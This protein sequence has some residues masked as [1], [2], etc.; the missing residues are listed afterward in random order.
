[1][2]S[3]PSP[4]VLEGPPPWLTEDIEFVYLRNLKHL[5]ECLAEHPGRP[6][7]EKLESIKAVQRMFNKTAQSFIAIIEQ[8][9]IEAHSK[10][11]FRRTRNKDRWA[12][13]EEVQEHLYVFMACAITLADQTRTLS[14][15]LTLPGYDEQKDAAF[16]KNPL[17]RFIQELR[18]DVMHITFHQPSMHLTVGN[19]E[20]R[21]TSFLIHS[22]Q[23]P[24]AKE[25]NGEAKQYLVQNPKGVDLVE[26]VLSYSDQVNKFHEWL[27]SVIE[28]EVGALISDYTRTDRIIRAVG[29]RTWWR[30]LLSQVVIA[31]KRDPYLY[32][33][34]HLSNAEL[35]EIQSL[36]HASQQQVDRIIE[37]VDED[38][39][40]DEELRVIVY[41]AFGV[42]S[43]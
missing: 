42:K 29:S 6:Y 27:R 3:D 8:F 17:H 20:N 7:N 5:Q 40:C 18:V 23:L 24:R 1:M 15:S 16:A 10:H 22:H 34:Q 28:T 39:A 9:H 25:Y 26:L 43:V 14:K 30:I 4:P 19:S 31:G 38:G 36:P 35:D 41:Q 32:L 11:L 33:N 12:L 2:F 13:Q 21:T 37:L